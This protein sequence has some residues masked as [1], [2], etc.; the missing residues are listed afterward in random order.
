MDAE[1][2]AR[3]GKQDKLD[4][5]FMAH[6]APIGTLAEAW[7]DR[8]RTHE[9]LR[10]AHEAVWK[11]LSDPPSQRSIWSDVTGPISAA[12]VSDSARH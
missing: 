7:W 5:A 11:T 2:M 3:D 1:W 10:A 9:E 12:I 4:P 6:T 8:W